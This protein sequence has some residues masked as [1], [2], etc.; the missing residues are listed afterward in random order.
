MNRSPAFLAYVIGPTNSGKS[1]LMDLANKDPRIGTIEVGKY[2]RAKYPPSYFKGQG[3]PKHTADEAWQ[4]Y[5]DQLAAHEA[6]GKILILADGQPRDTKQAHQVLADTRHEDSR[7]FIHMWAPTEVLLERAH[8]RDGADP[9]RL[10]LSTARLVSDMPAV[11]NV[12]SI[13]LGAGKIAP[14]V[15]VDT[16]QAAYRAESLLNNLY[17][18]AE[19]HVD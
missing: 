5:E 14:I 4:V 12:L 6:A 8:R 1:T 11:Y 3:N 10:A 17:T 7:V 15:H 19:H 2:M 18:T 9:E 13:L 16:S